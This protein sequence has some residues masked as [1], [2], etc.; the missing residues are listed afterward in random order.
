MAEP[1]TDLTLRKLLPKGSSRVEIWDTKVP[2]FGIRVSPSGH[3]S[4]V[5]VYRHK[6]RPRRMTLGKYPVMGLARARELAAQALRD[7]N[8]GAD[9][10]TEKIIAK[11]GVRF[12]ETIDLFINTYCALNNRDSTRREKERLLKSRFVR[13]WGARDLREIT[14]ADVLAVLDV[15]VAEGLPSAANHAL[16]D[17]RH[18]FNW[19]LDRG[20][21]E[22][23]PCSRIKRP[24]RTIERERVLTDDEIVHVRQAAKEVG[25]PFGTIVQLLLLTGQ[26][27][28]EVTKMNWADLDFSNRVWMIPS[29]L[30][31]NGVAHVVPLT[32]AVI[33]IIKGAPHIDKELVFP[34]RGS[35]GNTFSGF[36]KNKR[37]LDAVMIEMMSRGLPEPAELEPWTL[38]D[39]RRTV[40]TGMAGL[41]VA[42]HVIERLLN[43]VSGVLGGVAGVYNRF[44]YADEVRAA[45]DVWT[46]HVMALGAPENN[47]DTDGRP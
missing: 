4:F 44:K 13:R 6:G 9:P 18:F 22:T 14:K 8:D 26:R 5:L 1:L 23:S 24:A 15:T 11:T 17:I 25:Y 3:K 19:C 46:A 10:Q 32:P 21:I 12:D 43:H 38:H 41:G 7:A 16:A 34:A 35:E 27:R 36:S 28:N 47:S 33:E 2:G 20:L 39:L 45:L 37:R 31:K 40:S 30:T 42:P 29:E